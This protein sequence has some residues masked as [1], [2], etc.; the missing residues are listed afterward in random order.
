MIDSSGVLHDR[1]LITFYYEENGKVVFVDAMKAYKEM[2]VELQQFSTSPVGLP[3]EKIPRV[4][5]A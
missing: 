3:H 4:P 2:T 5:N 1:I